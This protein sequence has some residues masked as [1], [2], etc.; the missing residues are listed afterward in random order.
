LADGQRNG[1]ASAL[2]T[3]TVTFPGHHSDE[4]TYVDAVLAHMDA[5]PHFV[6]PTPEGFLQDLDRFLWIHDEPVG[7]FSQYAG[8]SVA[9]LTR[10][11]GVPVSLNGQ[12]GDEILSGYWQTYFVHLRDLWRQGRLLELTKHFAGALLGDGNPTLVAQIPAMVRRYR[13]RAQPPLQ[14][15]FPDSAIGNTGA[16]L[17]NVLAM[18]PLSRRVHEIRSMFLP[19]LLKWDDR[20]FMAFSVESRYPFL[21]HELIEL[22]LSFDPR[23]LY[24]HGWV[25]SPLRNGLKDLLPSAIAKRRSKFGFETPQDEWFT[26]FLRPKFEQWFRSDR[27]AW[28]Y[29]DRESARQLAADTWRRQGRH[30]EHCK[31]LF[32]IF[33]FDRWLDVFS[34]QG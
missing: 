4:R 6:T 11:A 26:G 27:P 3:F 14:V 19:Q 10:Q 7:G 8:Y 13:A 20:N 21:D 30:D 9:R 23:V 22:C 18:S 28:D 34:V 29:V 31:D 12:G 17:R 16:V 15:L 24:D 2:H 32:R 25:K 1:A 5:H 33:V